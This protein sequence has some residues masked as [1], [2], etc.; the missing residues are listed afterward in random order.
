[1]VLYTSVFVGAESGHAVLIDGTIAVAALVALAGRLPCHPESG[2][3]LWPPDAQIDS[4]V[5]E[6]LEF[7]LCLVPREPGVLD[8]L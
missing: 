8:L 4:M 6:H 1:M 2:R 7:R 5:D 3:D